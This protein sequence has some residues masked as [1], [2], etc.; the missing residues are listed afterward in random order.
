MLAFLPNRGYIMRF[1]K[2][3]T[4]A[5]V[6]A[7]FCLSSGNVSGME[8]QHAH[9]P[10]KAWYI[11][12]KKL[13]GCLKELGLDI[14][15]MWDKIDE[16]SIGK[17]V[18][19]IK[20][21]ILNRLK[22][23]WGGYGLD[24][25]KAWG[26]KL[27]PDS[28]SATEHIAQRIL[29]FFASH[30]DRYKNT[31]IPD[32]TS[33]R[34]WMSFL[35]RVFDLPIVSAS[36]TKKSIAKIEQILGDVQ[37]MDHKL[38]LKIECINKIRDLDGNQKFHAVSLDNVNPEAE[39]IIY[40]LAL[41][42]AYHFTHESIQQRLDH[43]VQDDTYLD[44]PLCVIRITQHELSG[45]TEYG[46]KP[47]ATV[48]KLLEQENFVFTQ[49]ARNLQ[50]EFFA[51][52]DRQFVEP[53]FSNLFNE[54]DVE[55]TIA[56]KVTKTIWPSSIKSTRRIIFIVIEGY[57]IYLLYKMIVPRT[58]IFQSD[59]SDLIKKIMPEH[60]VHFTTEHGNTIGC[61]LNQ[62]LTLTC[63]PQN[64][65]APCTSFNILN[66]RDPLHNCCMTDGNGITNCSTSFCNTSTASQGICSPD[67]HSSISDLMEFSD[68]HNAIKKELQNKYAQNNGDTP[69][70]ADFIKKI[71][72]A[73]NLDPIYRIKY[74]EIFDASM[75]DK[76]RL[77]HN[78]IGLSLSQQ[79]LVPIES[80]I[81]HEIAHLHQFQ[82][83]QGAT[84]YQLA[85]LLDRANGP[86]SE[87]DA[88]ILGALAAFDHDSIKKLA[89]GWLRDYRSKYFFEK[90][91]IT[92]SYKFGIL[93]NPFI[94]DDLSLQDLCSLNIPIIDQENVQEIRNIRKSDWI[95]DA[96]P[97]HIARA[98]ILFKL[99]TMIRAYVHFV[100]NAINI[101][102]NNQFNT[103]EM[104]A[105]NK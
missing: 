64:N 104:S 26:K 77:T 89:I 1:L 19:P 53:C 8:H 88:D 45:S 4:L 83:H 57:L 100:D 84:M 52:Y 51:K 92:D 58:T 90:I 96:H 42:I 14:E 18:E 54:L 95:L 85:R 3:Y 78:Q 63:C 105:S 73:F 94:Q 72:A 23:G 79:S 30:Q 46:T 97:N 91:C 62:N 20:R 24:I 60:N 66:N 41:V 56:Q 44:L 27:A 10:E 98:I 17:K 31:T 28:V 71:E 32:N 35:K 76:V 48:K 11:S 22:E 82:S 67:I 65:I 39:Q 55:P 7:S 93:N 75:G 68:K 47:E 81:G 61:S 5:L 16:D 2:K 103:T 34:F 102:P 74:I 87:I 59:A 21:Q 38:P 12:H 25:E 33:E 99:D 50:S 69:V 49:G 40:A 70:L 15:K 9:Q 80:L 37:I 29:K 13:L 43:F 6:V 101:C 86:A 36:T